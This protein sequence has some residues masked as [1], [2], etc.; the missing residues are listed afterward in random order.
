MPARF[1]TTSKLLIDFSVVALAPVT[2][3][4]P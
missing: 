1:A 3:D 4:A 2:D